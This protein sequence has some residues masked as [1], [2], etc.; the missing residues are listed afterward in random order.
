MRIK[1]I[2]DISDVKN[3]SLDD[4]V[5]KNHLIRKIEV[6]MAYRWALGY[7]INGKIPVML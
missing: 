6:N 3:I 1:E 7:G 4:S 5:P 2:N